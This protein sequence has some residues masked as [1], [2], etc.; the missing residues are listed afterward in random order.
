MR[1]YFS[2]LRIAQRFIPVLS[3]NSA[4][5]KG[6]LAIAVV[7]CLSGSVD[8]RPTTKRTLLLPL[9]TMT[10]KDAEQAG[11]TGTGCTWLGGP[12]RT[13]RISMA[14]DRAAVK[15]NG[16]IVALKK[17]AGAREVF[18]FTYHDWT[19]GGMTIAIRD[20]QKVSKRGNEYVETVAWLD[21][22]ENGRKRSWQGR[23]NC[24]S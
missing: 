19:G 17:V 1:A 10:Y 16:K 8:A 15:R 7:G 18:P 5:Q 20:T 22:T 21:L 3:S 13:G 24:G 9:E 23:L 2:T 11:A 4:C 12:G 14:D 6:L